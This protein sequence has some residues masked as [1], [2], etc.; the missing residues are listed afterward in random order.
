MM[1]LPEMEH[2]AIHHMLGTARLPAGLFALRFSP[3]G[4]RPRR[5]TLT[6]KDVLSSA[7]GERDRIPFTER[8]TWSH[9][10]R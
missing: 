2:E 6:N 4:G 7:T 3:R 9:R 1:S 10:H 5:V 8:R